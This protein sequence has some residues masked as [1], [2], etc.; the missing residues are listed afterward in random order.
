MTTAQPP[1][2]NRIASEVERELQLRL[3]PLRNVVL[4]P[5]EYH[6]YLHPEDFEHIRHVVPRIVLD[7]QDCLNALVGRLNDRAGWTRWIGAAKPPIEIPPGGW[8]IHI[9][10]ALNGDVARGELGIHSRLSVPPQAS[11]GS[12]AGTVRVVQTLV[13]GT[14][15]RVVGERE[16]PRGTATAPSPS[17]G[18]RT[19]PGGPR[20]M[21]SDD[22][23][24]HVFAL[25]KDL[26]KIGRGGEEYWVDLTLTTG[27]KVSREHCHIRRDAAG[28]CFLRDVSTWGSR[29]NGQPLAKYIDGDAAAAEYELADGAS[30]QLADA[31]LL[32]F[33]NR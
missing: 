11:Y 19:G 1:H 14:D 29:L 18:P 33:R 31:V 28:A 26:T 6:V 4:A 17:T 22:N 30:I 15:R 25:T 2:G 9:H 8:A 23:G 32:E 20:L 13:S 21:Y 7:V 12:G 16:E 5:S 10:P 27:T 24:A 3:F